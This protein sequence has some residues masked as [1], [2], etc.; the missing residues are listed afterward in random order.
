MKRIE[1]LTAIAF[2]AFLPFHSCDKK[3]A[4]KHD[5]DEYVVPKDPKLETLSSQKGEFP[6]VTMSGRVSEVEDVGQDFSY[7]IQYS[8]DWYFYAKESVKLRIG[9]TYT[10]QP[11]SIT[12][13][14]LIPGQEY[15]YR[16]YCVNN[17]KVYNGPLK[18][19]KYSWDV[20]DVTTLSAEL[21]DTGVVVCKAY[22]DNLSY[23]AKYFADSTL[24]AE[25]GILRCG[26]SYSPFNGYDPYVTKT[27]YADV[28]NLETG[29][30]IVCTFSDFKYNTQYYYHVFF[31]LGGMVADGNTKTFKFIFV[32]KEN[33]VE[34]GYQFI[35]MGLR[36]RWATVNVGAVNP[37]DYGDH[38]AWGETES[39][40][41]YSWSNYKWCNGS[42]ST[43]TKY[44]SGHGYGVNDKKTTLDEEDD[45]AHVRWGGSWRMPSKAE[46]DEL[47]RKCTWT[48]TTLNGVYGY[49]VTSNVYGYGDRSIFL[50]VTGLGTE[51]GIVNEG[52]QGYYWSSTL[53]TLDNDEKRGSFDANCLY[54][55]SIGALSYDCYRDFGFSVRPVCPE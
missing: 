52:I 4:V 28:N 44:G 16:T 2:I 22:I 54:V 12:V 34:N 23:I 49:L 26:I 40:S 32:P 45:V 10:D 31:R 29:D 43:L 39:K 20:P 55:S 36:V 11:F 13:S 15:F 24:S 9:R 41:D 3:G 19:F 6:F 30:T 14:D 53:S 17:K 51:T 46:L 38:F 37:E 47:R 27:V 8:T 5:V 42:Y 35:E 33:G 25:D 1:L 48:E 18:S 7:G 50:P 21:N